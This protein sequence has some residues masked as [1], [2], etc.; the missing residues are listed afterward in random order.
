MTTYA[1]FNLDGAQL[2]AITVVGVLELFAGTVL[3]AKRRTIAAFVA[4]GLCI[5]VGSVLTLTM[6]AIVDWN[7][8]GP[9]PVAGAII[10]MTLIVIGPFFM[11]GPLEEA[12]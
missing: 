2:A 3:Y 1:P 12:L 10:F 11:K 6:L 7:A 4:H 9:L 8:W 5:A